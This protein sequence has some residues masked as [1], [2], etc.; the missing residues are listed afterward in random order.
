MPCNIKCLLVISYS[1][2]YPL[3]L[4]VTCSMS[5]GYY[6]LVLGNRPLLNLLFSQILLFCLCLRKYVNT[7][8]I[9]SQE[10]MLPKFKDCFPCNCTNF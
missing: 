8:S 10:S 1:G 3:S 5:T 6:A 7:F 4:I 9:Y 2:G